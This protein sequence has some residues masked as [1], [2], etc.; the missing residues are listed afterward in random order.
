MANIGFIT[1]LVEPESPYNDVVPLDIE[2]SR[3]VEGKTGGKFGN[4][5]KRD[6][7]LFLRIS[8]YGTMLYELFH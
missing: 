2:T 6:L 1:Y 8:V 7:M 4:G 5:P 3:I